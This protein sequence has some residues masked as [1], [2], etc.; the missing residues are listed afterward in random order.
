MLNIWTPNAV[1]N[2]VDLCS[3]ANVSLFIL[4]ETL[5]GYYIHGKAPGGTAEIDA[6][7]LERALEDESKG[8]F[9]FYNIFT[10]QILNVIFLLK[11]NARSRGLEINDPLQSYEMFIPWEMRV[12]Y[13]G[14]NNIPI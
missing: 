4:D 5:H 14:V 10:S 11:G 13:K 2:F 9:Q 12:E 7:Q 3:V 6:E 8:F 1:Q